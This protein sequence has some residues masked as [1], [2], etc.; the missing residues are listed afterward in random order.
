MRR[1]LLIPAFCLLAAAQSPT[2]SVA[3]I[4]RDSTTGAPVAGARIEFGRWAATADSQGRFSI[5]KVDPGRYWITATDDVRAGSGGAYALLAAAD[6]PTNVEIVVNLGGFIS[7]RVFDD[8]RHPLE[9]AAVL[10]L[11]P[12]FSQGELSYTPAGN[13]KTG[14][15]GE[16]RIGPVRAGRRYMVLAKKVLRPRQPVDPA[17]RDNVLV[18]T[19]YPDT[20]HVE[21]GQPVVVS[22]SEDRTGVDIRLAPSPWFCIEGVV[23]AAS[24]PVDIFERMPF[25][26]GWQFQPVSV[27]TD[28]DGRFQSCGFHPGEYRLTSA[29]F[30]AGRDRTV[31]SAEVEITTRDLRDVKLEVRAPALVAGDTVW[32]PAPAKPV[33]ARIGI[34]LTTSATRTTYA[35]GGSPNSG[36][37]FG[38]E[39][40]SRSI[41]VPG[42][43]NLGNWPVDDYT[44]SV[45]GIPAGCY[46]KDALWG[47]TSVLHEPVRL[48]RGFGGDIRLRV[49]L[50]C[51]AGSLAA[52]VTDRDG[53]PV[54][55]VNLYVIP[56]PLPT[57]AALQEVVRRAAVQQGW[58]DPVRQ[59]PPGKYLALACDLELDGTADPILKLGRALSKAKEVEVTAGAP[60]Q[61]TL[62]PVTV[63]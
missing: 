17:A 15:N 49:V 40:T 22:P 33:D 52:H 13:A 43:F 29:N 62:E 35:D 5:R 36:Y 60:A 24:R 39:S 37:A 42:N 4:V 10:V 16:Y 48:S 56:A 41:T 26:Q 46:L 19:Y 11:T 47:T 53:A 23:A 34:A 18:P 25:T 45:S 30:S 61:V 31:A 38:M 3:G 58:S 44:L 57:P 63:E 28:A 27:K 2:A 32:D 21:Q 51:D 50:A 55:N 6:E 1:F 9:G 12:V 59:L 7:G 54:S 8:D 14:R 20:P